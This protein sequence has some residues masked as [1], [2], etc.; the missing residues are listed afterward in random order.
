[1]KMFHIVKIGCMESNAINHFIIYHHKCGK[2]TSGFNCYPQFVLFEVFPA[3]YSCVH[4]RSDHRFNIS[5]YKLL[6]YRFVCFAI[7]DFHHLFLM[8][9]LGFKLKNI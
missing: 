5:N 4:P 1:M 7:C 2:K 8:K 3:G 6:F 9:K